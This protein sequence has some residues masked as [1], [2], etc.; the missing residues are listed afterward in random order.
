MK[1]IWVVSATIALF[2]AAINVPF[3]IEGHTLNTIAFIFCVV[4]AG[5]QYALAIMNR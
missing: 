3:A 2:G 1:L 4:V 5:P